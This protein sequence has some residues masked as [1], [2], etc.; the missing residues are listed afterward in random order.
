MCLVNVHLPNGEVLLED[1]VYMP[2]LEKSVE[3][4]Y[5]EFKNKYIFIRII[6]KSED[7]KDVWID[8]D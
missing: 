3:Y 4:Y 6:E 7:E 8:Y 1:W 2:L 5:D